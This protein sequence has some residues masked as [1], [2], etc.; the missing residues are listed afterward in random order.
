MDFVLEGDDRSMHVLY[1]ISP[2]FTCCLLFA[3]YVCDRI[4]TA[5]G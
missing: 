5:L 4:G 1:T 2:A 3:S